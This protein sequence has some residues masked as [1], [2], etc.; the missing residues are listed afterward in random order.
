MPQALIAF[1]VTV[2]KNLVAMLLTQKMIIWA[3]EVATSKTENEIDDNVV[4]L[5][6]AGYNN[7]TEGVRKAVQALADEYKR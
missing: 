4:A 7:D 6:K 5:V 1:F 2:G 3:L